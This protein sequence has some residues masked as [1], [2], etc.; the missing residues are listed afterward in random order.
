MLSI[1]RNRNVWLVPENKD[2][3]LLFGK[4]LGKM[5]LSQITYYEV[6][7]SLAIL[8]VV[9]GTHLY[10]YLKVKCH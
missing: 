10:K 4:R 9:V 5:A 1:K 8:F 3:T 2:C 6:C 7:Q